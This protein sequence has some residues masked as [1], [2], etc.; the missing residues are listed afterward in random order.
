MTA[1]EGFDHTSTHT[2]QSVSERC[3]W[4]KRLRLAVLCQLLV[5]VEALSF[6]LIVGPGQ[7][8][9][10]SRR[11]LPLEA[12]EVTAQEQTMRHDGRSQNSNGDVQR[13]GLRNRRRRQVALE[14]VGPVWVYAHH[15]GNETADDNEYQDCDEE[16][17]DAQAA[18]VGLVD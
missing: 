14:N 4:C 9:F 12:G 10:L 15:E 8:C 5:R 11:C 2:M 16:F 17:E 3:A 1:T 13:L 7:P 6:L 18:R